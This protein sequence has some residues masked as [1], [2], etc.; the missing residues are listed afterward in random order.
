MSEETI[1]KRTV[2]SREWVTIIS[3][4]LVDSHRRWKFERG[5]HEFGAPINDHSFLEQVLAG[6]SAVPM[7]AGVQLDVDLEVYEEKQGGV[8]VR[9]GYAVT[10]VYDATPSIGPRN[11]QLPLPDERN[12]DADQ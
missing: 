10:H 9:T 7:Q 4:V 6:R 5:G 8:W 3:P 12:T 11:R 2:P 1:L